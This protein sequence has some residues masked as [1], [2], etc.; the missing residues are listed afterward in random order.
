MCPVLL[1][2]CMCV[3][4]CIAFDTHFLSCI[5]LWEGV[6]RI[7]MISE[8]IAGAHRVSVPVT[9][10]CLSPYISLTKYIYIHI[11]MSAYLERKSKTGRQNRD[12]IQDCFLI[13]ASVSCSQ[14]T[15]QISSIRSFQA[16]QFPNQKCY[17]V[18]QW[19][20]HQPFIQPYN[21]L[22]SSSLKKYLT[23]WFPNILAG[24]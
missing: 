19:K 1:D 17:Y 21:N 10:L 5:C 3:C 14:S 18:K 9:Q 13:T 20:E 2:V 23:Q 11:Y 22:F 15:N 6:K 4:V 7:C 8:S 16:G 12:L 24:T